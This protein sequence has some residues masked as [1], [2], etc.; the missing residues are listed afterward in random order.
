[1][2]QP[3]DT[4]IPEN[5][6]D[7]GKPIGIGA[8]IS[9]IFACIFFSGLCYTDEWWGIF[10]FVVVN[11][12]AGSLVASVKETTDGIQTTMSSFRGK[13][14]SGAIDGFMFA[15]A[16]VPPIMFSVAMIEVFDHY[17]ATR[18]AG[19]LLN[20]I[21]APLLGLPGSV[22]LALIASLQS[23]DAGAA[24]T[25][26]LKDHK[27]IN[28]KETLIFSAFQMTADAGIG[29]FLS[30]GIVLF[31]LT[32]ADGSRA[33]PVSIGLCLGVILLG[34]VLSANIMRFLVMRRA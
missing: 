8:Y 7:D 9:F 13:G 18:A 25:R 24:L 23:T 27:I 12:D 33:V 22:A 28:E 15:L 11:G 4:Q 2:S 30:S 1:M 34:K 10:D 21:S 16:L 17:G 26:Q 32:L 29:N 20:R 5:I 19:R 31:T 6:V 3:D 14:G